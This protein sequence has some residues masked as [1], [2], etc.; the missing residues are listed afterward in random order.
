MHPAPWKSWQAYI[1]YFFVFFIFVKLGK[2]YYD[3][4]VVREKATII[5][6]EMH[7]AADKATDDLQEQ[8]DYQDEFVKVVHAHSATMLELIGDFISQQ[9]DPV[10]NSN[11]IAALGHLETCLLYQGDELLANL[12]AFTNLIINE[13]LNEKNCDDQSI[14]T[15]NEIPEQL[16]YAE[17]ATP[18][19]II[20]YE[21][22]R[23]SFR[24]ANL[25]SG[26]SKFIHIRLEESLEGPLENTETFK[27]SIEDNIDSSADA[28][29]QNSVE[30]SGMA[31]VSS[32]AKRLNGSMES[33]SGNGTKISVIF[34]SEKVWYES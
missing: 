2:E 12:Q 8:L 17:L 29:S 13:L 1:A 4:I 23:S 15:I 11:R 3:N 14:T 24:R 25:S 27:L 18:L 9:T 33:S 10:S 30:T 20:I 16:V 7:Y 21:L 32:I 19:S 22:I 26:V 34:P 6:T 31:V 28:S 5:A